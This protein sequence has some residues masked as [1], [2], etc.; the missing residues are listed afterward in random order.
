MVSYQE[1]GL[2]LANRLFLAKEGWCK[3]GKSIRPS[4]TLRDEKNQDRDGVIECLLLSVILSRL[5]HQDLHSRVA[6]VFPHP[7]QLPHEYQNTCQDK[8]DTRHFLNN[9]F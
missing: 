8:N 4:S 1:K 3:T 5:R 7:S 9:V 2:E 6:V